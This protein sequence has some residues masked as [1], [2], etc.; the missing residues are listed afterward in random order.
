MRKSQASASSQPPPRAT[1]LTAAIVAR[2]ISATAFNANRNRCP[3]RSASSGPPNS[4]MSAPAANTR[5]PPVTT[6][7]PGGL[8]V[9]VRAASSSCRSSA[10]DSAFT[11]PFSSRMTATPSSRRS[12]WTSSSEAIW[13]PTLFQEPQQLV[14]SGPGVELTGGDRG[15]H[16]SEVVTR[17]QFP[18]PLDDTL[19]ED[20]DEL[21]AQ[22]SGALLLEP[23]VLT[24]PPAV[25]GD[26]RDHVLGAAV[27]RCN[28]G[29]DGRAPRVRRK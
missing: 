24:E 13:R 4:E 27:G 25:R 23:A 28:G 15:L 8:S 22:A 21:V 16:A 19:T 14:S 26:T 1:P 9:S 7:A 17:T 6:T 5:S 10:L 29:H 2:G 20:P 18:H 12:T 3:M 11:L